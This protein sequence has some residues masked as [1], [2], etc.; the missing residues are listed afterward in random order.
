MCFSGHNIVLTFLP[1]FL[2]SDNWSFIFWSLIFHLLKFG[3]AF[4]IPPFFT[5][6]KLV[7]IIYCSFFGFSGLSG[8]SNIFSQPK[9]EWDGKMT[10]NEWTAKMTAKMEKDI[11]SSASFF[12]LFLPFF[13][14][15]MCLLW[16]IVVISHT[17]DISF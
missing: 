13:R 2:F 1:P 16:S 3:A 5:F 10:E 6:R 9:V 12:L 15:K 7:I 8:F 11:S 17:A 14:K 4:C